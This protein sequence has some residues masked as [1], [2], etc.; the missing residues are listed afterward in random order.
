MTEFESK[1]SAMLY[2]ALCPSTTELGEYRF[3]ML[4]NEQ[5]KSIQEH[6]NNCPHCRRELIQLDS[7]LAEVSPDL[8]FSLAD[9]INIWIARLI[10]EQS[11]GTLAPLANGLRGESG[12]QRVYQAGDAQLT[13]DVQA[14]PG[15]PDRKTLI[16]LITGV[17]TNGINVRLWQKQDFVVETEVDELGNFIISGLEIGSYRLILSGTNFEIHVEELE[18]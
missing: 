6:I 4:E 17:E 8:D 5:N 13:F 16:G 18:I 7:Y 12:Q 3:G 15:Q 11:F 14:D 2:R 10:P 1:L 9:R